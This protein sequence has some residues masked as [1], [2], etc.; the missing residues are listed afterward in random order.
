MT[1]P[2]GAPH[3][4][5]GGPATLDPMSAARRYPRATLDAPALG[6]AN[7]PTAEEL[8]TFA[9]RIGPAGWWTLSR[10][11]GVGGIVSAFLFAPLGLVLGVVG[12][13]KA[14]QRSESVRLPRLA[15]ILS[16]ALPVVGTSLNACARSLLELN[17]VY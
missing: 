7:L 6:G 8:K 10:A 15:W 9:Q 11:L 2:D 17:G 1:P 3:Q 5:P 14:R 13:Y 12:H 4:P 16:I